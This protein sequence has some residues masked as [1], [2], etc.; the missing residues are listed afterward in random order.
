[1]AGAAAHDDAAAIFA[2]IPQAIVANVPA[3]PMPTAGYARTTKA[4]NRR[5]ERDSHWIGSPI[6]HHVAAMRALF[7]TNSSAFDDGRSFFLDFLRDR[8]ISESRGAS[9]T[10]LVLD[11]RLELHSQ[12]VRCFP[13]PF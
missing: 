9:G 11:V 3:L 13:R 2:A 4:S 6:R 8:W 1:M 7:S 12:N 5:N 10:D